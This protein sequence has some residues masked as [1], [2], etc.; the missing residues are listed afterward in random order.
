MS[1]F[2]W[3]NIKQNVWRCFGVIATGISVGV[4]IGAPS[5]PT[6][7]KLFVFLLFIFMI[8]GRGWVFTKRMG[9]FVALLLVYESFRGLV[10]S[11]NHRV[12]YHILPAIDRVLGFGELPTAR[13]QQWLW[14]GHLQWYDFAFY[15]AYML[16]FVLPVALALWIW[17]T[18]ESA[19]WQFIATY[20]TTSFIG[21]FGFLLFPASPPWLAS[22]MAI[23]Q[24][25]TR[26]SSHVWSA[27]GIHDFPSLY[28][29]ISPNPVAAMPS[30]HAAYATLIFIFVYKLYGWKWS[31]LA[32]L[33]PFLIY[34][35]TIYQGEHYLIDEIAGAAVAV[36]T[37]WLAP[38]LLKAIQ[39]IAK[40]FFELRLPKT[41]RKRVL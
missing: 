19:Y 41:F 18:R 9:P 1:R 11:L 22:D 39:A 28:N 21:F 7:D 24:P 4:F 5:W 32:A 40:H 16:H 27:F 8:F 20:L 6:P 15:G 37:Y 38:K 23:I 29:R 10:P 14:Q 3:E 2:S 25:I 12:D 30:L 34:M 36:L 33:Y 26:I 17:K 13:L 35:G 31:L